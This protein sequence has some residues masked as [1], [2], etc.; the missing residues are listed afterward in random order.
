MYC[1]VLVDE[2][3]VERPILLGE[4]RQYLEALGR[5]IQETYPNARWGVTAWRPPAPGPDAEGSETP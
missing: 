5:K 3:G 2:R 1:L 4:S